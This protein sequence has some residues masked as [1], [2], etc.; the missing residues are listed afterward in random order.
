MTRAAPVE[1]RSGLGRVFGI[2]DGD[3]AAL[4]RARLRG[5]EVV[6]ALVVATEYWLRAVPRW[7]DLEPHYWALL[8]VATVAGAAVVLT[9]WRRAGFAAIAAAH[10]VLVWSEFPSTGNHAYLELALAVLA[11]LLVLDRSGEQQLELRAVRWMVVVVLFYSGLQKLAQG[12]YLHG[13][14]LA[15][16]LASPSF[17][18]LLGR[19]VAHD[20]LVR[21]ASFGGNVGDGPYRVASW[22][23]LAASNVTWIAELALAPALCRPRTRSAAVAAAIA[24]LVVIEVGARELF[25]GL[26]FANALLLF[27]RRN[28]HAVF[29]PVAVLVLAALA[30]VR[31]GALPEFAFY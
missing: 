9:P 25:F 28:A 31:A 20:E 5:F 6:L 12:A 23:L 30:L 19:L 17:R 11:A 24:L 10:A 29:L 4:R 2:V 14:Y 27:A 26:V 1:L 21:L 16:S 3:D 8:G 13:E 18:P 15:F 7:N 22:P